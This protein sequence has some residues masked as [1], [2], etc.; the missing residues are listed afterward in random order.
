MARSIDISPTRLLWSHLAIHTLLHLL[1]ITRCYS[2]SFAKA[3][4][5]WVISI[6]SATADSQGYRSIS[7]SLNRIV[8]RFYSKPLSDTLVTPRLFKHYK[9]NFKN[10]FWQNNLLKKLFTP[11]WVYTRTLESQRPPACFHEHEIQPSTNNLQ[12]Y[13][14][15]NNSTT[16]DARAHPAKKPN[17][18]INGW[19]FCL[20]HKHVAAPLKGAAFLKYTF[21]CGGSLS[22]PRP[23]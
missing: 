2:P 8:T 13:Y 5:S 16:I 17:R 10:L 19:A 9:T 14:S 3:S 22:I 21:G 11:Q 18:L 23:L 6:V 7:E 4:I 15:S 1:R 20:H 12:I